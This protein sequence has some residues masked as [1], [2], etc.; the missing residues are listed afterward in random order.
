MLEGR[1]SRCSRY[2]RLENDLLLISQ[3]E[4]VSLEVVLNEVFPLSLVG[5]CGSLFAECCSVLEGH[6]HH[7]FDG[8]THFAR[9][10]EIVVVVAV[11]DLYAVREFA[12]I[13]EHIVNPLTEA[14][15]VGCDT[16][17]LE[18]TTFK[19]SVAPGFVVRGI[20]AEV[21]GGEEVVVGHIEDAV[22]A[23]QIARHENYLYG[24]VFCVPKSELL[25]EA[26]DAVFVEIVKIVGNHGRMES[27]FRLVGAV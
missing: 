15:E 11:D 20:E 6:A 21:V 14:R 5:E 19:G 2:S 8:F 24:I 4:V 23:F 16:G 9:D 27:A 18:C 13:T 22:S 12:L 10:V 1:F 26:E 7:G 25:N 3:S 17:S